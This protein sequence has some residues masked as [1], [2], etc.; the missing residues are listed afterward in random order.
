[1]EITR[2]L[3]DFKYCYILS[4]MFARRSAALKKYNIFIYLLELL[5][6][7]WPHTRTSGMI[8]FYRSGL[9]IR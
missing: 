2:E 7:K 8:I 5:F 9:H 4:V 6:E 3:Q 1:M